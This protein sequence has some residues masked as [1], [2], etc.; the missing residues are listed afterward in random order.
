MSPRPSSAAPVAVL[1]S[2]RGSNFLALHRACA[3]GRLDARIVLVASNV[4]GAPGLEA[5][6]QLG[7]D[8]LALPHRGWKRREHEQRLAAAVRESGAEWVC[9]AGYMRLLRGPLIDAYPNRILNI[10]PSLLPA[11]PGLDAQAQ[12]FDYGVKVSGATV[13]LVDRGMDTGPIVLQ[14]AVDAEGA[15]DAGVLAARILEVEHRL[16]P[17]ALQR[18]LT[19]TWRLEGRRVVFTGAEAQPP[20]SPS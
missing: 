17:R 9:L 10:H 4:D 13:H 5:A 12:A 3:D 1:L 18:L 19:E 8:T 7:L 6:R 14:A 2:G 11:F 15:A 16:Y 20:A